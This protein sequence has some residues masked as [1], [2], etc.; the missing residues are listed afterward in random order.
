LITGWTGLLREAKAETT[1][2]PKRTI[3]PLRTQLNCGIICIFEIAKKEIDN[4]R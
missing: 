4:M 2:L 3:L 1:A